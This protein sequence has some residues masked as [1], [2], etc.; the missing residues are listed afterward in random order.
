MSQLT[1]GMMVYVETGDALAQDLAVRL[2]EEGQ[3]HDL[4][5][6]WRARSDK[7]HTTGMQPH[8]HVYLRNNELFVINRDGTPSHNSDLSTL[9]TKIHTALKARS[10]LE[11]FVVE[12]ASLTE[13]LIPAGVIAAALE[14]WQHQR[15]M[16]LAI[17]HLRT[18]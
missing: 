8:V 12:A 3:W 5:K 13:T 10:L 1:D 9:P 14:A 15:T 11:S 17:G 2:I 4:G 16:H 18:S 7:P 6:G